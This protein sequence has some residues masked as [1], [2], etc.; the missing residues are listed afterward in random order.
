MINSYEKS[1]QNADSIGKDVNDNEKLPK[2]NQYLLSNMDTIAN[3]QGSNNP[4]FDPSNISVS[5]I[6]HK[7]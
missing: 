3:I 5:N 4:N 2:D 6:E 1:M 7:P